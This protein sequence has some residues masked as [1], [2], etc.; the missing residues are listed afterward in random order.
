MSTSVQSSRTRAI[1]SCAYIWRIEN[2]KHRLDC[3]MKT[4]NASAQQ[5]ENVCR[6]VGLC[7]YQRGKEEARAGEVRECK[8]V[9]RT[10]TVRQG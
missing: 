9:V 3:H 8:Q 10:L 4:R 1:S 7:M 5:R 6:Y 2:N